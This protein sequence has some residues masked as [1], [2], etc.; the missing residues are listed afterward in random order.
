MGGK[1]HRRST[2]SIE[3]ISDLESGQNLYEPRMAQFVNMITHRLNEQSNAINSK[4]KSDIF[5]FVMLLV[6]ILIT[7]ENN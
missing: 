2:S 6:V 3:R 5:R 4:L 7:S 1:R